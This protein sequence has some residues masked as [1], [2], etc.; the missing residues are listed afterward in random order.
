MKNKNSMISTGPI[1]MNSKT[2]SIY[3]WLKDFAIVISKVLTGVIV[4]DTLDSN[5]NKIMNG[6]C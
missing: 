5:A 3:T 2:G 1:S 4:V 6:S